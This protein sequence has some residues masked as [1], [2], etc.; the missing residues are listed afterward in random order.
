MAKAIF[1]KPRPRW[2]FIGS[3]A[4]AIAIEAAALGI[5]LL[6]S[7]TGGMA[8]VLHDSEHGYLFYP[9][10]AYECREALEHA[11]TISPDAL[12]RVGDNC[13]LLVRQSLTHEREAWAYLDVF[14]ETEIRSA[15]SGDDGS[16]PVFDTTKRSGCTAKPD[17]SIY[18]EPPCR[19]CDSDA[20]IRHRRCAIHSLNTSE[21]KRVALLDVSVR[22]DRSRVC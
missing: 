3:L 21:H 14:L 8:D 12:Q 5:P 17:V 13:R 22:T 6:A 11:A 20:D 18:I 19:V 15:V 10:D 9:G 2:H 4:A 16:V 7:K 1:Y